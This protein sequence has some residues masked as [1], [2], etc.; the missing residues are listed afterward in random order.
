M[1]W[2]A[3]SGVFKLAIRYADRFHSITGIAGNPR[4][5]S[6]EDIA[7]LKKMKSNKFVVGEKD[8]YW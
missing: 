2:S 8:I 1:G 6:E 3:N 7:A 5:L 4:D